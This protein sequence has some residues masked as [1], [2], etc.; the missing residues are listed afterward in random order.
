MVGARRRP[1]PLTGT[2][3]S[4]DDVE[5]W[6]AY[7]CLNTTGR[8]LDGSE[9]LDCPDLLALHLLDSYAVVPDS[10]TSRAAA[11][12]QLLRERFDA[13]TDRFHPPDPN[14]ATQHLLGLS[15][16]TSR[17]PRSRRRELCAYALGLNVDTS[18]RRH[19]EPLLRDAAE[20]IW[21]LE[22]RTRLHPKPNSHVDDS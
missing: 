18:Q 19:E 9:L 20:F 21:E 3:S 2:P 17:Q 14:L 13:P 15:H 12:R 22:E 6:L 11:L 10:Q 5:D 4:I 16:S 1:K 8:G 7:L